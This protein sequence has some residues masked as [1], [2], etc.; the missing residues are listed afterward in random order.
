MQNADRNFWHLADTR[1]PLFVFPRD[2]SISSKVSIKSLRLSYNYMSMYLE[3][4]IANE[5]QT[6]ISLMNTRLFL[7]VVRFISII[8]F[9]YNLEFVIK[10][11]DGNVLYPLERGE[12]WSQNV[13]Q[14]PFHYFSLVSQSVDLSENVS[15]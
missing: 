1:F 15:S 5:L 14:D 12:L 10:K 7:L 11:Q 2:I 4:N 13:F 3:G 9:A 8:S 6:I